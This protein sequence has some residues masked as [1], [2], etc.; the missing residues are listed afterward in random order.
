CASL[1]KGKTTAIWLTSGLFNEYLDALQPLFGQLRY[2]IIGGDILDP[3][4]IQRVLSA[5]TKP[6]RL[7]NGYGPTETTTFAATY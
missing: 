6:E 2:L 1:I 4:K 3:R 5:D 7:I